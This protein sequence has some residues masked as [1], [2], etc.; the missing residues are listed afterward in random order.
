MECILK[1]FS[2]TDAKSE[3]K[4]HLSEN[5]QRIRLIQTRCKQRE[6]ESAPCV[7]AL[8][9]SEKYANVE[10]KIR[11]EREVSLWDSYLSMKIRISVEYHLYG[12][13]FSSVVI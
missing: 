12:S 9:K 11:L 1:Y 10:S 7:K 13:L 3:M 2:E 6:S 4:N 5:M 8:W